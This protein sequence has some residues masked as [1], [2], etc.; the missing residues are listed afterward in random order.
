MGNQNV[1][2]D[3][4]WVIA[5][6]LCI[7]LL[8]FP[9]VAFTTGTLRV[10]LAL[11]FAVFFPGY[12]LLA[13]LFPRE[14]DLDTFRRV[15]FSLGLSVV[16]L[17]LI[18]LVLNYTP[19]GIDPLPM[20][21]G[22]SLFV[23][24]T[25]AVAW[26]RQQALPEAERL[27][28]A[29]RAGPSGW[30]EASGLGKT[31]GIIAVVAVL[32]AAGSLSYAI[33]TPGPGDRYTEFYILGPGGSSADYDLEATAGEPVDFTVVIVNHEHEPMSYRVE[34]TGGG[35]AARNLTTG[36]LDHEDRWQSPV[37]IV[38]RAPGKDQKVEFW[39]YAVG[40]PEPNF[41]DPLQLYID[42]R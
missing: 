14:G 41:D 34:I 22:T 28:F 11:P 3:G 40:S 7:T 38:F 36:T 29:L 30:T 19:W 39:L 37:E 4:R 10:V 18:G 6:I 33:S 31:L 12:S 27:R 16:V 42:V 2:I 23:L 20:L 1:A 13:A 32:T 35:E 26:Y 17:P 5:G 9:V 25:S 21:T 8:L 24:A 15:A